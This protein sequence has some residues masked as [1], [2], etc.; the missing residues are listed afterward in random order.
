MVNLLMDL[1]S[2]I[3]WIAI[4]II[5][6]LFLVLM[7]SVFNNK[8][9]KQLEVETKELEN[10]R[11]NRRE[12]SGNIIAYGDFVDSLKVRFEMPKDIVYDVESL[13]DTKISKKRLNAFVEWIR[14][15]NPKLLK[16]VKASKSMDIIIPEL[17]IG[18]NHITQEDG[19]IRS[20]EFDKNFNA[21]NITEWFCV[22]SEMLSVQYLVKLLD[23]ENMSEY[24]ASEIFGDE[25][26]WRDYESEVSS[27]FYTKDGDLNIPEDF[28]INEYGDYFEGSISGGNL[29]G[30][31]S[32]GGETLYCTIDISI[33]DKKISINGNNFQF[34]ESEKDHLVILLMASY[35]PSL[36]KRILDELKRC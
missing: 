30:P 34:K 22:T 1:F 20:P 15:N 23:Y 5:L 6:L 8:W 4:I 10:E 21:Y 24:V 36:F 13:K 28:V 16:A 26:S 29:S 14:D 9:H 25:G 11:R 18:V 19:E 7:F 17:I 32:D 35:K 31:V 3:G 2:I 27:E 33:W 12:K